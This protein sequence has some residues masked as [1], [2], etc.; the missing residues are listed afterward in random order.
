M[1]RPKK[2]EP[3]G[4]PF[5]PGTWFDELGAAISALA[6]P[7]VAQAALATIGTGPALS[8]VHHYSQ[9]MHTAALAIH[10]LISPS[11]YSLSD[12]DTLRVLSAT[13]LAT[14]AAPP[15]LDACTRWGLR[16]S[17]PLL[18][19]TSARGLLQGA[20]VMASVA[21]PVLQSGKLPERVQRA[22][23]AAAFRPEL[24]LQW[25]RS[26]VA[27]MKAGGECCFATMLSTF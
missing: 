12:S 20:L 24:L 10:F 27:A 23:Q 6:S 11:A 7:A 25:L 1:P 2:P 15:L 19:E 4:S 3:P 8:P 22:A 14:K 26:T 16:G 21:F 9:A 5:L 13:T 18:A 17:D